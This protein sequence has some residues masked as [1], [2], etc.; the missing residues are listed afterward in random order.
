MSIAYVLIDN[1]PLI[2]KMW[3]MAAVKGNVSIRTYRTVQSF[4]DDCA[5]YSADVS[6]YIDSELDNDLRGEIE[7]QKIYDKGFKNIY[8]ASGS[9]DINIEDYPWI[10][11]KKSKRPPF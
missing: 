11:D 3:E 6:I 1:D 9:I 4:L 2:H 10:K 7:S 8:L 5:Q